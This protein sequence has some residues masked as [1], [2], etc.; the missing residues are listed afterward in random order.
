MFSVFFSIKVHLS[1]ID[2]LFFFHFMSPLHPPQAT[3][4]LIHNLCNLRIIICSHS[5][6]TFA[7]AILCQV[8][9]GHKVRRATAKMPDIFIHSQQLPI[10]CL[11]CKTTVLP[12]SFNNSTWE[13]KFKWCSFC[14]VKFSPVHKTI[15]KSSLIENFAGTQIQQ[16]YNVQ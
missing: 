6:N 7:L 2:K 15:K 13:F 8:E 14:C 16:Q 9:G 4:Y 12:V 1:H 5:F 3:L 11:S 10:I